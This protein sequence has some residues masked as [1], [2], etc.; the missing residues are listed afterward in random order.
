[1]TGVQGLNVVVVG[2]GAMGR[3]IAR[4]FDAAG[5]TVRVAD[6][7]PQLTA[8]G[9][10]TLR[11]EAEADGAP[12]ATVEEA[13][14]LEAAVRDA[15]LLVEAIIED[16]EVKAELLRR[17]AAASDHR[18]VVASNTSSLS[19]GAM[20]Q[21]YGAPDRVVGMHF[22][23]P[24]TKMRLVEVV[25]GPGTAPEVVEAACEWTEALGKTA[26]VCVDSPNFI[27]NRVCRPLYYEA[28]LLLTQGHEPATVDV[29]ARRAL[30]HRVG[31]LELLDHAGLHTHLGS[32]ETAHRELGDPRYRPIPIAR[33]L[34][35]AGFTGRAAGRGFYDHQ[36]EPPREARAR[37]TR[38]AVAADDAALDVRGPGG[39]GLLRALGRQGPEAGTA[40][41]LYVCEGA[42]TDDD[43][44]TVQRL[45]S[46]GAVVV[47]S[48]DGR[49][50]T[51]LPPGVGWIRLH[52]GFGPPFAEVVHDPE[53]AID[54]PDAVDVALAAVGADSVTVLAT[55]GLIADRL[56]ACL[57]NEAVT[58]VE[59]GIAS[60]EDV[61]V[62]LRLGMNHPVG[63]MELLETMGTAR[64]HDVLSGLLRGWGDPRYR[65]TMLLGRW[66]AGER[67]R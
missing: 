61:D 21:A 43:V 28:Q 17:I 60:R 63:P 31:P 56:A 55:P 57:V 34:V 24:P 26:V 50:L 39:E 62:A 45:A 44:A 35:G 40:P 19:I 59:E 11:E 41:V 52:H 49:W 53:A 12:V 47:D 65:P 67:R 16:M 14:D 5:A 8:A 64:V 13:T 27:V 22:F 32:S 37:V 20:G 66:A 4:V 46:Q 42:A 48:S 18:M 1:V 36:T 2:L 33:R 3:G 9:H 38:A 15:D 23:N 54:V 6:A 58:L 51:D 10:R 29:V 25:R 30:G 7:T